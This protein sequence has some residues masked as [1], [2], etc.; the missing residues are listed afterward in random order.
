MTLS[1]NI[2]IKN[3]IKFVNRKKLPHMLGRWQRN[4][5][6][7]V[8]IKVDLSNEDHCGSCSDLLDKYK[9]NLKKIDYYNNKQ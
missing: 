7:R 6:K 3:I 4:D 2:I 9:E 1:K 8:N 5:T